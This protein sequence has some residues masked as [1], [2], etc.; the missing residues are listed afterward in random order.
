MK[1]LEARFAEVERRVKALVAE[2]RAL[3]GRIRELEGELAQ[4]QRAVREQENEHGKKLRI[5]EKVEG[6]LKELE[7]MS[8][9]RQ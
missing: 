2:N 8:G 6:M 4:A 7:F 3:H 5:R 1:N 9:E